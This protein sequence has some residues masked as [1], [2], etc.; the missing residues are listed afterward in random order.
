[1]CAPNLRHVQSKHGNKTPK[2]NE[3]ARD[4]AAVP[5]IL[6]R[7]FGQIRSFFNVSQ[8]EGLEANVIGLPSNGVGLRKSFSVSSLG[9]QP[10]ATRPSFSGLST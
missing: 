1:V 5:C 4:D 3:K 2:Q 10:C 7:A 6:R 9:S 8:L